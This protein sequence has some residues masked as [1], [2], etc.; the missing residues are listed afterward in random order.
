[1]AWSNVQEQVARGAGLRQSQNMGSVQVT[2][3]HRGPSMCTLQSERP[4]A[5]MLAGNACVLS[6][7]S[8]LKLQVKVHV[9]A[10]G[11]K[12]VG[13]DS[14]GYLPGASS[15]NSDL[16]LKTSELAD[17]ESAAVFTH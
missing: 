11:S 9:S 17:K 10:E 13:R 1:M 8:A 6:F 4:G 14:E 2:L 5:K 12:Q 16:A 15:V 3:G 7:G